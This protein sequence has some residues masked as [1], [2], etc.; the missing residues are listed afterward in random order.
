MKIIRYGLLFIAIS[1]L[2]LAYIVGRAHF[3]QVTFLSNTCIQPDQ[4]YNYLTCDY[5]RATID[6][7]S[8]VIPEH[9]KTDL[10]SIPRYLWPVFAPQ[11][12]GF[13]SPAILHDYLYR[14]RSNVTR[15]FADEV[16]YSALISENVSAFTAYKFF[17]AVRLFGSGQFLKEGGDC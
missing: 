3:H 5:L 8:F 16:L 1:Y 12:S 14:C 17:L 13:V 2:S 6:G 11:Y 7:K 10:A 9:F 4:G 15:R